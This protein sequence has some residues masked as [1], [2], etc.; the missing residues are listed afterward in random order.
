[1]TVTIVAVPDA[2]RRRVKLTCTTTLGGITAIEIKA[3]WDQTTPYHLVR[4]DLGGTHSIV[5]TTRVT[6]DLECP[7]DTPIQYIGLEMTAG[8]SWG[9]WSTAVTLPGNG[10]DWAIQSVSDPLET[11][12]ACV[13]AHAEDELPAPR[14]IFRTIGRADPIVT[15][16]KRQT[17]QGDLSWLATDVNERDL[18]ADALGRDET[19]VVRASRASGWA[20]RSIAVGTMTLE[21]ADESTAVIPWIVRHNWTE[22]GADE[23]T[24]IANYGTVWN[25]IPPRYSTWNALKAAVPSWNDMTGLV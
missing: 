22:V 4:G 21:R 7:F 17:R 8:A 6:Y 3:S 9:P 11:L 19:I 2:S 13:Q 20:V 1:M 15:Y 5:G 16:G 10:D 14:G 25:D 12:W 24:P 23:S 18:L